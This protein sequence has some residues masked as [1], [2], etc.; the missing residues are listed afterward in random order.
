MNAQSYYAYGLISPTGAAKI[1]LSAYLRIEP[2]SAV[3]STIQ[4]LRIVEVSSA[5]L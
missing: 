5:R 1:S 3:S 4:D 2:R